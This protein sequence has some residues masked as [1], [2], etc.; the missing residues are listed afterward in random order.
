MYKTISINNDTYQNLHAI[1]TRL[2]KPKSQV[3]DEMVREY[4]E[5]MNE[6]EQKQLQ[7]FNAF[8]DDLAKQV[9]LPEGVRINTTD[10]DKEFHVLKDTDY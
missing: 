9:K 1:A 2:D 7:K 8:V 10:L 6:K 4:I 5:Q 3:I